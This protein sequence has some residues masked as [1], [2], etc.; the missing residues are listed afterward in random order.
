MRSGSC[1]PGACSELSLGKN[2]CPVF[3]L[4]HG[5][6]PQRHLTF[7]TLNYLQMG[8]FSGQLPSLTL[9]HLRTVF[10]STRPLSEPCPHFPTFL[11][12]QS[13]QPQSWAPFQ[14]AYSPG[15]GSP[16]NSLCLQGF[17]PDLGVSPGPPNI[18]TPRQDVRNK[19]MF[20]E[21]QVLQRAPGIALL[22]LPGRLSPEQRPQFPM[23]CGRTEISLSSFIPK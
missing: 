21:R 16:D 17:L 8:K 13:R 14:L 18:L 12:G 1:G 3:K 4:S 20:L 11:G 15:T 23:G 22:W 6:C 19:T 10:P 5:N 7:K 9:P 2:L